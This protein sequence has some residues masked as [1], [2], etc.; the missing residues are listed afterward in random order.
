MDVKSV[1][2]TTLQ[3]TDEQRRQPQHGVSIWLVVAKTLLLRNMRCW[4]A[5]WLAT[6][7]SGSML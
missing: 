7:S 5:G 3:N 1:V 2:Y 4:L 6:A